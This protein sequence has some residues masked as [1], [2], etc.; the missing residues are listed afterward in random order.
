MMKKNRLTYHD[1]ESKAHYVWQMY[2]PQLNGRILDVGADEC[3]LKKHLPNPENYWGIGLGGT[4]DQIV[5]LEKE[6]IP[7]PDN[8]FDTVL[9]LDVLEHIDNPHHIFD[10]LCR[11]SRKYVI[12][13][14][15]NPAGTFLAALF[16]RQANQVQALKF[17]GLPANPPE[18]RHK[19]FF[20]LPEAQ[21]FIQARAATNHMQLTQIT[22]F[23]PNLASGWR[24]IRRKALTLL[25][26][27]AFGLDMAYLTTGTIWAV[28]E[29]EQPT[30]NNQ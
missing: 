4:P 11:V 13:S 18:D 16:A 6:S 26:K 29:K 8:S 9:C 24:L 17:Y 23:D 19:W 10:E 25:L 14:L 28:L 15:P 3:H 20:S 1:R 2:R 12:I 5:N 27:I 30:A 7:F 22:R 21:A